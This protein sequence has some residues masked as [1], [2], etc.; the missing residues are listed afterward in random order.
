MSDLVMGYLTLGDMDPFDMVTAAGAGGFRAAGVRLTG[1]APDDPWPFDPADPA[2]VGRMRDLAAAAGVRL[3]NACTYR[4]T[5]AS[6]PADYLPVLTACHALGI[7]TL[8]CN[9]FGA[10]DAA[11][12]N[13]AAVA[14]LAAPLGIRLALEFIPVSEVPN[15]AEAQRIV[16]A[17]GQTNI[18]L[19][20][21]A[22]HLWRSGGGVADVLAADPARLF[23]VQLCDG[24]LEPPADLKGEMRGGRLLPGTGEFDLAALL[25]AMPPDAEI[26]TE[27][28]NAKI[29]PG[30]R[31]AWAFRGTTAFL[32]DARCN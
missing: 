7:D 1:H 28:P 27:L 17:T 24:P 32:E 2:H 25:A 16:Q 5:D 31:A 4:F 19:V 12:R 9:S 23:A 22:L 10:P 14:G 3:I 11:I 26:E 29:P 20:V 30:E 13:L 21:D 15:I 18:G 6:D 8:I